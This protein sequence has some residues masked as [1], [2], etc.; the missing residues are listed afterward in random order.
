[1]ALSGAYRGYHHQDAVT[2]YLLATL[3]L[4]GA[5]ARTLTADRK[6]IPDDCFDD[7]ELRGTGR[8]RIQVKSH[9]VEHRPLQLTDFTTQAISFRI[10]RAVRTFMAE[11]SAADEYR[12]FAT[13]DPPD[14]LSSRND[15]RMFWRELQLYGSILGR[16]HAMSTTH[17]C[18]AVPRVRTEPR[19]NRNPKHEPQIDRDS[20]ASEGL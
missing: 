8:R 16:P 12:L 19:S 2:A 10:D 6:V 4:P 11:T 3:L 13:Y 20:V 9:Q 15:Q 18:D 17:R 1:M 5:S 7:I 14:D